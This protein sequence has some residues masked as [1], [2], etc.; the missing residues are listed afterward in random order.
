[1]R[2]L[3]VYYGNQQAGCWHRLVR[4]LTALGNEGHHIVL[5]TSQPSNLAH[6]RIT[7]HSIGRNCIRPSLLHLSLFLLRACVLAFVL[8]RHETFDR[9]IVFD[10]HNALALVPLRRLFHIPLFLCI[11]GVYFHKD[12]FKSKNH[13]KR[14]LIRWLNLTGYYAADRV[15]FVSRATQISM[16]EHA[17]SSRRPEKVVPNDL[18]L[19]KQALV[20]RKGSSTGQPI[21]FGY[22]G[23]LVGRK[24]VGLLITSFAMADCPKHLIIQGEGVNKAQLAA[25]AHSLGMN[26]SI[27]FR[28]WDKNVQEFF[29][30]ID[31]FVLPSLFDDASNS[32]LEA[33]G[34]GKIVLA[35]DSGGSSEILAYDK[36]LLF[37]PQNGQDQLTRRLTRLSLDSDYRRDLAARCRS[38]SLQWVFD[39]EQRM[40]HALIIPRPGRS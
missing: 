35:A 37:S 21:V 31:V 25:Q 18:V 24:N 15:I 34:Y 22:L 29:D 30:Q 40:K 2:I 4:L 13:L 17:G 27:T 28:S 16:V 6:P 36:E 14:W 26:S 5:L 32:L 10:C 19:Q 11:R 1:M 23:Q 7:V 9:C 8:K 20:N 33:L 12:I 38:A 3:S 39:W